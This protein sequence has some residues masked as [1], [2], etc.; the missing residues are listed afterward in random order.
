MV[1][2]FEANFECKKDG[3]T[4]TEVLPD[5]SQDKRPADVE[6]I[7]K[8]R[9]MCQNTDWHRSVRKSREIGER[10]FTILNGDSQLLVRAMEEADAHGEHLQ[11]LIR[12]DGLPDLPFEVL[13]H[14]DFL[15]PSRIHLIRR[16]SNRGCKKELT[17]EN[18][19]LKVLFLACS[20]E[21]PFPVLEYEKEEEIILDVTKDLPID[22]DVEDTGSLEGLGERLTHN[23]YD[24]VH[25]TGHADI[26][27]EGN[28]F[29]LM[30][31][32]EGNP[33]QVTPSELWEK[34][35]LNAPQLLFLSGCRTGQISYG[36]YSF[37]HYLVDKHSSTVLGWGLPVTDPGA[38]IAAKN[39]YF[40]LSRGSSI[41]DAV[42]CARQKL[43]KNQWPDWS[44]LRL[45]SDGTPLDVPPVLEGQ[46]WKPKP[47]ELQHIYLVN[48]QVKVLKKGFVGRR[49]HIQKGIRCL[50][51]N[52]EK[53]GLFLH[54]TG[55]L[56]KSCLAG[57][58]CERFKDHTLVIVNGELNTVTFLEALKDAFIRANDE[59]GSQILKES[60][61]LPDKIRKLCSF[62]FRE[63]PYLILLDDFE[64]NLEGVKQGKPVVTTTA[65]TILET[66]LRYLPYAGKMSQ[67]I[68][69]SRYTFPLTFGGKNLV[70]Q[71]LELIGLTSFTGADQRKKVS[72]LTEIV[73]YPDRVIRQELI[74]AGRG[75]PRLME[76]LNSLLEVEKDL[77]AKQ[78][79]SEIKG[80][81]EEFVQGLLLREIL[82][83]QPEEF[84]KVMQY[85]AVYRVP[86][87]KEGIESVCREVPGWHSFLE[88]AVQLS[89][90]EENK[91]KNTYYWVTPLLR[92]EIFG[93]LSEEE[94]KMC[95]QAASEHY[96]E[97]LSSTEGYEPIYAFELIEHALRCGMDAVAVEEGGILLYYLQNVL[98]YKEALSEGMYIISQITEL[99]RDE[100]LSRF[101]FEF[102]KIL[103]DFGDPRKAVNYFEQALSIDREVYGER[104]PRVAIDLNDL[105]LAWK[106]LG[107][108]KKAI[109]YYEQAL[110]IDREVYGERHPK[111]AATLNNL[112]LARYSLG[113]SKKAIDYFE[114]ALSIDR[115]VYGERHPEVAT[116][117]NNLGLAWDSLGDSKKAIDYYEQALSILKEVYGERHP[118]VATTLNNL[119]GAWDSLGDSKKAID[120]FE[121]A[122]SIDREVYGERHPNVAIDIGNLGLAWN[123]LGDSKKA[124][125]YFEQAYEIFREFYGDDHP[126][127]KIAKESLDILKDKNK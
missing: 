125:D 106:S 46:K 21:G 36:A 102:G 19:S 116:R 2:C 104:H 28:P 66:L 61:E 16:V 103:R 84:Q 37:A 115:E 72:E 29:F 79:L 49:R 124:I 10:L 7:S 62:S 6:E 67:M 113:D 120:Y 88:L 73:N 64:K 14:S 80:K 18:R 41:T 87:L 48:S 71:Q 33:V 69:T 50:R 54:G 123:S 118:N 89:L 98:A 51:K 20:P 85:S 52:R 78:L 105:G 35:E 65:V 126:H 45:F 111:V 38:T 40:E 112:G 8:I 63:I 86:V 82:T 122:L 107:D 75:N 1:V 43:F 39:L 24:V 58:L 68:I 114:Q 53:I 81:Q 77:D 44:L 25:L 127:T 3:V 93:K 110:S 83:R 97:V 11:L 119:G 27:D 109:D 56:G 90:I 92:D 22:V 9:E 32:E 94:R 76:A 12:T 74:E 117:L 57:K 101:L 17:P 26:D 55:G 5:G 59:G 108:S 15:V 100:K 31:D 34:L 4:L 91:G 23:R 99:K 60:E 30:E 13:Y 95:H 42:F 47:R 121:Q 70:E 96:R